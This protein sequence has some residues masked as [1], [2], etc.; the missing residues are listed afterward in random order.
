MSTATLRRAAVDSYALS[1][2]RFRKT[3]TKETR[4]L[5]DVVE[6]ALKVA[7][8]GPAQVPPSSTDGKMHGCSKGWPT[9][10][11]LTAMVAE[12]GDASLSQ[13]NHPWQPLAVTNSSMASLSHSVGQG[14]RCAKAFRHM[15]CVNKSVCCV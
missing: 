8:M 6:P 4:T 3:T 15:R 2:L 9:Q 14:R 11:M 1:L 5:E 10:H 13:L 7:S 12:M